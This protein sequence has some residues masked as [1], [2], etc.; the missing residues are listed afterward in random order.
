[1]L[2]TTAVAAGQTVREQG[3]WRAGAGEKTGPPMHAARGDANTDLCEETAGEAGRQA[4]CTRAARARSWVGGEE[5]V[6]GA[7]KLQRRQA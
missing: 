6:A 1:M 2:G 4:L 3:Q 7:E 5:G